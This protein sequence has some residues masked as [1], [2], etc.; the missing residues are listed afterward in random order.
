MTYAV[1]RTERFDGQMADLVA[2]HETVADMLDGLVFVLQRT[3]AVHPAV[4][5]TPY[6]VAVSQQGEPH[7]RVYYRVVVHEVVLESADLAA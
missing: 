3:P 7:L 4:P 2:A 1:R 6:R 5:G